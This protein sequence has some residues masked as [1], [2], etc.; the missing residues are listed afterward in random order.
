MCL[1][2]VLCAFFIT[3]E[4]LLHIYATFIPF[5]KD[6]D[7]DICSNLVTAPKESRLSANQYV[8][9]AMESSSTMKKGGNSSST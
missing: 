2:V 4:V 8:K 3:I 5:Y 7:K 9:I 1:L 6:M